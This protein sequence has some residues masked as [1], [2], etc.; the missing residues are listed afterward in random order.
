MQPARRAHLVAFAALAGGA[1]FTAV[2]GTARAQGD[3][4]QVFTL[5]VKGGKV[6]EGPKVIKLKRD[7]AVT[8]NITAD[9]ADE[10]HLHGYDLHL[11]LEAGKMATL[12]FVA[13][14]TGRFTFELHEGGN[15]LGAFEIYPK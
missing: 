13:K 7:D 3:A 5:V 15:E 6:V 12:K 11:K 10:L 1:F 4:G 9:R 14:R 8:L 2:A